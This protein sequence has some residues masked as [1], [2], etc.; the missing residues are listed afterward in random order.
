MKGAARPLD[1]PRL[2]FTGSSDATRATSRQASTHALTAARDRAAILRYLREIQPEGDTDDGIQHTLGLSGDSERPRRIELR[3]AGCITG[4]DGKTANTR[5]GR[6]A[7]LWFYVK[8]L[9]E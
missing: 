9:S 2:P 7:V 6:P 1:S 3:S 4:K 5:S 8:E